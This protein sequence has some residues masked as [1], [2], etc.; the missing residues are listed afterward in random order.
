MIEKIKLNKMEGRFYE[1]SISI[2]GQE[3]VLLTRAELMIL[4]D[5]ITDMIV[6][7]EELWWSDGNL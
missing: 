7:D 3:Q 2:M 1:Y 4:Y 5:K 6:D